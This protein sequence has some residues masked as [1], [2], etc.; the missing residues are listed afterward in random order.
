MKLS[1]SEDWQDVKPISEEEWGGGEKELE[2]DGKKIKLKG[3]VVINYVADYREGM[4]YFRA[5][6]RTGEKSKRVKDLL[7]H[8]LEF[9]VANYTVWHYRRL[10]LDHLSKAEGVDQAQAKQI[11]IDELEKVREL[12]EDHPKNYQIWYHRQAMITILAERFLNQEQAAK[13]ELAK[14][15][16]ALT[17][18]IFEDDSKNYHA[19]SYRQW[20]NAYFDLWSLELDYLDQLLTSDIR[21]NSAWNHRFYVIFRLKKPLEWLNSNPEAAVTLINQEIEF[22]LQKIKVAPNNESPWKYLRGTTGDISLLFE[23]GPKHPNLYQLSS[24]LNFCNK[25]REGN[26]L[27]PH[28]LSL[29]ADI[30]TLQNNQTEAIKLYELLADKIDSIHRKYWNYRKSQISA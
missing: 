28:L 4:N 19:W 21:N 11:Y 9:N 24:L 22:A 17:A 25:L 23:Y 1:E 30:Y 16:L 6:L 8:L 3:V 13:Q 27:S 2:I 20:V 12:A 14:G 10:V 18:K 15:E 5:I 26:I 7:T 29:L